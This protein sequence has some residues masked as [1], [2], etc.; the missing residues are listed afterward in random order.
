[1]GITKSKKRALKPM[2]FKIAEDVILTSTGAVNIN[3][4]LIVNHVDFFPASFK[5]EIRKKV[6]YIDPIVV[7]EEKAADYILITHS[8]QD[9]FSKS[10]IKKLL[11]KETVIVCPGKVYKKL[12]KVLPGNTLKEA[13]PGSQLDFGDITIR[14]IGAYNVKSGFIVPHPKSALYVGYVI[15]SGNVKIY[16]AGDTDY[17][18]EMERLEGITAA[19]IPIDGGNLTMTNERAVEFTNHIKPRYVIPMHY[20]I[21]SDGVDKFK[22]L[23]NSDTEVIVMDGQELDK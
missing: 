1:M 5:L 18:S 10:D 20:N 12:S 2:N 3:V 4:P 14:F 9:H 15:S 17:T 6:I 16:H 11:K 8:H 21:R 7:E 13:V 23:I 19:L 22:E